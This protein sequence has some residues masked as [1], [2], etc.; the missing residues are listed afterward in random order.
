M[1]SMPLVAVGAAFPLWAGERT[2]AP[3]WMQRTGLEWLYRLGQEPSRLAG[4]YLIHNPLFLLGVLAQKTGW[5]QPKLPAADA[6]P[7]YWG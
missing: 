6:P 2:M 3:A 7:E 4:R 5:Q 1:L